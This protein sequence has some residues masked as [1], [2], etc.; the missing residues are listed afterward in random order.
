MTVSPTT[1]L[2]PTPTRTA[3]PFENAGGNQFCSDGIDNDNNG[4]AD[5]HDPACAIVPPCGT[6]APAMSPAVL[7]IMTPLLTLIGLFILARK[8][9]RS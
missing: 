7:V 6:A 9:Q 3:A 1:T 5:C 4:L 8:R 2:T